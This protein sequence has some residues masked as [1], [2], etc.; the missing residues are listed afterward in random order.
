[1]RRLTTLVLV[2][3]FGMLLVPPAALAD[4]PGPWSPS[5]TSSF[6]A[7]AGT[8]CPFTLQGDVLSDHERIRTLETYPDGSPRVQE[9]VGQL[10]MRFTNVDT[11]ASVDRNL[12]GTGII[13]YGTDGSQ[14]LTLQ[15]GHF[16]VG[17]APTDEGGP[18]FLIF[19][20][21]GLSV[22][23]AARHLRQRAGREH[24]RNVGIAEV[25]QREWR[26]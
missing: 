26:R 16:A 8:R 6:T 7:E 25:A 24:L 15:G 5:P 22:L 14:T 2:A 11:G 3:V 20:G 4:K 17:L 12:T 13:E 21:S 23:I 19:T 10:K 18:A 9:V 1:M